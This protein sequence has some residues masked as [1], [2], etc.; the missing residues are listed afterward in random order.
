MSEI[1]IYN[2]NIFLPSKDNTCGIVTKDNAAYQCPS[3][4]FCNNGGICE[5]INCFEYYISNIDIDLK[6]FDGSDVFRNKTPFSCQRAI[7]TDGNCGLDNNNT[8]CPNG[9]CCS[10]K[11]KCGYDKESCIYIAPKDDIIANANRNVYSNINDVT[12]YENELIANIKQKYLNNAKF[13]ISTNGKC[14]IDLENEKIFKCPDNKY[15]NQSNECSANY[16]TYYYQKNNFIT[17][18][19]SNVL[20]GDN[21]YNE[22]NKWIDEPNNFLKSNDF[23]GKSLKHEGRGL[24]CF[25]TNCCIN[26]SC[27]SGE[28]CNNADPYSP[29]NG[30]LFNI[31]SLKKTFL[32]PIAIVIYVCIFLG[33]IFALTRNNDTKNPVT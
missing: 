24:K 10:M 16:D 5:N 22:Y 32:S 2:K 28:I 23:C 12:N 1:E 7:S 20:Y 31:E 15:C 11:G 9:Q 29:F 3:N 14:G 33:L 4:K 27:Q 18:L 13:E 6:K 25:G 17:D 21:F 19:S 30:E 26:N 8:K